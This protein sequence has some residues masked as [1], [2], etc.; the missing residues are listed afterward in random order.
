[1]RLLAQAYKADGIPGCLDEVFRLT[2]P[3][4]PP[5]YLEEQ[6]GLAAGSVR[7]PT[8]P[9]CHTHL[10]ARPDNVGHLSHWGPIFARGFRRCS[11]SGSR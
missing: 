9:S 3:Y 11:S 10:S 2:K 6:R 5:Y 4:M 7:T 8:P 1:M